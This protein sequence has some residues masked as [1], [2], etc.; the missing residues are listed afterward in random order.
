MMEIPTI[1][2]LREIIRSTIGQ[3][4]V[5]EGFVLDSTIS[6]AKKKIDRRNKIK[7]SFDYY[8]FSPG[9]IEFRILLAFFISD[10]NDEI[11][12]YYKYC[13][14]EYYKLSPTITLTEGDFH[15]KV[16]DLEPKL[17]NAAMHIISDR[18]SLDEGIEDCRNILKKEILPKL[19]YFSTLNKFQDFVMSDYEFVT[20]F[21]III[22]SIIALKLK[23]RDEL[24]NLVNFIWS[25]LN[26]ET[27]AESHILKKLVG[28]IISYTDI[29]N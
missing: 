23:G 10:I 22:P 4:L 21:D 12:K 7:I 2:N 1:K 8:D 25:K 16:K 27:K 29:G 19:P 3:D 15:P 26:L 28:N 6:S 5:N 9:R 24:V 20:K 13:N 17:R 18:E 14:E 11:E